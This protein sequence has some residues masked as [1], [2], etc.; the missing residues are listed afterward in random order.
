VLLCGHW[1]DLYL[2]IMPE[3]LEAPAAGPLEIL[4]PLGYSALFFS[5]TFRALGRASL[6]PLHDPY[7]EESLG[8]RDS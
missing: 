3:V 4:L 2:L 5:L 6:V 7:L 1:L 8:I